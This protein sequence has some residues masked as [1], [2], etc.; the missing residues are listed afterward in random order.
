MGAMSS[1]T[2]WI[3]GRFNVMKLLGLLISWA[4]PATSTP[5]D[6]I[7]SAWMSCCCFSLAARSDSTRSVMSRMASTRAG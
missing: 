2:S 3:R 7:L 6:T 4:I 5:S 1:Q